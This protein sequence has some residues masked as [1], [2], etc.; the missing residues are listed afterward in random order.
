MHDAYN[1]ALCLQ[2]KQQKQKNQLVQIQMEYEIQ[3]ANTHGLNVTSRCDMPPRC[4]TPTATITRP[5]STTPELHMMMSATEQRKSISTKRSL[6]SATLKPTSTTMGPGSTEAESSMMMQCNA[7]SESFPDPRGK[8]YISYTLPVEIPRTTREQHTSAPQGAVVN[9]TEPL[10]DSNLAGLPYVGITRHFGVAPHVSTQ[11]FQ[12][13]ESSY[14][15]RNTSMTFT[16]TMPLTPPSCDPTPLSSCLGSSTLLSPMSQPSPASSQSYSSS[17]SPGTAIQG[18]LSNVAPYNHDTSQQSLPNHCQAILASFPNSGPVAR[19]PLFAPY[20]SPTLHMVFAPE[21]KMPQGLSDL[22]LTVENLDD[23]AATL[24]ALEPSHTTMAM[25]AD[26]LAGFDSEEL[27]QYMGPE[28]RFSVDS[29]SAGPK[30]TSANQTG[31]PVCP[32]WTSQGM[33][34]NSSTPVQNQPQQQ[35]LTGGMAFIPSNHQHQMV[36]QAS[37]TLH[38][39]WI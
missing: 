13:Q 17:P 12:A 8:P 7:T 6:S 23:M 30:A 4:S 36:S 20:G 31:H 32:S 1:I 25:V 18:T 37:T 21:C 34:S 22:P 2:G 15:E 10:I 38:K 27:G 16:P 24:P 14:P 35:Q 3:M 11:L 33:D 29:S 19:M 28:S 39:Y 26:S 5:P 9:Q